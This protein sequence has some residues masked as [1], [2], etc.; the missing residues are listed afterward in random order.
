MTI[1]HNFV[2]KCLFLTKRAWL[3]I[4]T[5]VV[6]LSTR[7]KASDVN[8]WKK[9]TRMIRYLRGSIDM[10]MIRQADSVPAPLP[11]WWVDGSHATPPN[12]SETE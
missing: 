3:D 5:D 11:K 6:F 1:Y 2:A 12:T 4:S 8:A 7:V 9:L 10:S